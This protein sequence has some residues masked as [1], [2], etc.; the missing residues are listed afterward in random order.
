MDFIY[1][2]KPGLTKITVTHMAK[3]HSVHKGHFKES[4]KHRGLE[5]LL[6]LMLC[7]PVSFDY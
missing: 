4:N 3:L 5:A 1:Q 6:I 7:A 2:G